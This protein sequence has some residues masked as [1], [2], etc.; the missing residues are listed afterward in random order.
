MLSCRRKRESLTPLSKVPFPL[1]VLLLFGS[2]LS[3]MNWGNH[4]WKEHCLWLWKT[5]RGNR[6]YHLASQRLLPS[7]PEL[8]LSTAM[9]RSLLPSLCREWGFL[10]LA[11]EYK[12]QRHQSPCSADILMT[13]MDICHLYFNVAFSFLVCM[14]PLFSV[15]CCFYGAC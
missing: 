2:G 3:R 12:S 11:D 7:I 4:I 8:S 15:M 9:L 5:N 1:A 10:W 14:E 6:F 13:A